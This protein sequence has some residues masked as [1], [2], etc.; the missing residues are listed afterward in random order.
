MPVTVKELFNAF[1]LKVEVP[2]KFGTLTKKDLHESHGVYVIEIPKKMSAPNFKEDLLKAWF[3]KSGRVNIKGKDANVKTV[4]DELNKFWHK[5]ETIIYIG[6]TSKSVEGLKK[7]LN[8]FRLHKPGNKGSHA[9]GYWSKLLDKWE[10]FNVHYAIVEDQ[11]IRDLEFK[12]LMYFVM[13][14]ANEKNIFKIENIGNYLPFANLT[15]DFDTPHSI[16]G[17]IKEKNKKQK[18]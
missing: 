17:A 1:N 3:E 16:S 15:A 5:D 14:T 10:N 13:K 2:L 12:M 4:T 11:N 18:N 9:G 8:D 7:R 6:Q